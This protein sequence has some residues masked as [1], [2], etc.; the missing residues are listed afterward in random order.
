MYF[1]LAFYFIDLYLILPPPFHLLLIPL[2]AWAHRFVTR[3]CPSR[4]TWCGCPFMWRMETS[5]LPASPS[6]TMRRVSLTPQSPEQS[7]SRSEPW[8]VTGEPMLRFTTPSSKVRGLTLSAGYEERGFG[9]KEK[10]QQ[11]G[12]ASY[13][14]VNYL[15]NFGKLSF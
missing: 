7:C 5:T 8:M 13:S 15:P 6:S 10:H 12:F 11:H 3:R 1:S 14:S 4:G 9:N 2:P